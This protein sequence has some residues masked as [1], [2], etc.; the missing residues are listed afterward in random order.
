MNLSKNKSL[1]EWISQ[2]TNLSKN[3]S[4]EEWISW[5]T[6]LSKNEF[7]EERF[8]WRMLLQKIFPPME[9]EVAERMNST[10]FKFPFSVLQELKSAWVLD[11]FQPSFYE[12]LMGLHF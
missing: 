5:R 3:E 9:A 6:N 2:W 12:V 7:R 10:Y 1:K 8:S 11:L 4:L